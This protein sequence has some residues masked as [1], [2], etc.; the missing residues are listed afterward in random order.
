MN[1]SE[2]I[3]REKNNELL[4]A[5]FLAS[6]LNAL[7]RPKA[8]GR[9][10]EKDFELL[11]P[12]AGEL[13]CDY[14][15]ER[16]GNMYFELRNHKLNEASGLSSTKAECW[17]HFVPPNL[18]F[19]YP[20]EH[21]RNWLALMKSEKNPDYRFVENAGDDN[22]QGCVVPIA[23]IRKLFFVQIELVPF[24]LPLRALRPSVV[25]HPR[26]IG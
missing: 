8:D 13:K 16:S 15:A 5:H 26:S 23:L 11:V 7:I 6:K 18:L 9:D 19:K 17:Y 12:W 21:M 20:P 25:N 22:S 4:L 24:D 14:E 10:K 2:S 1:A 3:H